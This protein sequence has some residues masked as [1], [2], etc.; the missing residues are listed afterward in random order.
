M[1]TRDDVYRKFGETAEAAQLLETELGNM[2]LE[3]H[4]L[5]E[6]LIGNQNPARAA[7]VLASVNR[8]TLGQLLKNLNNRTQSLDALEGLL[9][10]ALQERN[11][12]FHSYYPKHN[13]RLNSEEGR[14]QMLQD[15]DAIHD[16]LL[17]AYKAVMKLGGVDLD[18]E[19]EKQIRLPTRHLPI[20]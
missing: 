9:S 12:L 10:K 14:I 3:A 4:V 17:D 18:A 6:D 13:F 1:P 8:Q 2:L 16:A 19:A 15:L 5:E 20:C 7:D 11:R